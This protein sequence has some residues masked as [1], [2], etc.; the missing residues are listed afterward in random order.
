MLCPPALADHWRNEL[1][2]KFLIPVVSLEDVAATGGVVVLSHQK[3]ARS[4]DVLTDIPWDMC[5]LDEAHLLANAGLS[6]H[7][8]ANAIRDALT[9]RPKLLLTATPMQNSLLDLYHL[10]RFVDD[11]TFP[12][13]PEDFRARYMAKKAYRQELV[14]RAQMLC[15]RTLRW[16]AITMPAIRRTVRTIAVAPSP[17][18]TAL[19]R[20]LS[21]YFH[22]ENLVAFPKVKEHHIRLTYW[23]MLASSPQA[24]HESL[25]RLCERLVTVPEAVDELCEVRAIAAMAAAIA[26][27]ARA[28]AFLE[29]LAGAREQL[30]QVGAP[31]KAVVFSENTDTLDFLNGLLTRHS[32]ECIPHYSGSRSK[33][34]LLDFARSGGKILL[35]TDGAGTGLDLSHC[36]LVVNYD[37]P[38]NMQKLEQR[39]SRCHRYGQK[40]D[41]LVLN[42]ID[43]SNRADRRLY[44]SLNKKL[45][46][47]DDLFGASETLLGALAADGDVPPE[48]RTPD[49]IQADR[50]ATAEA[51]R[52]EILARVDKA[53]ADLLAHF[54][55]EVRQRFARYGETVPAALSTMN[56]WLWELTKYRLHRHATFNETA[57]IF[58]LSGSPY[59]DLRLSRITFGMDRSLPP[60]E[61][62]HLGHPLAR[63]ILAD[64]QEGEFSPGRLT[65]AAGGGFAAGLSGELGLWRLGMMSEVAHVTEPILCGVTDDGAPLSHDQCAGLLTLE[66]LTCDGGTHWDADEG[67]SYRGRVWRGASPR[68]ESRPPLR[69]ERLYA[70]RDTAFTA[71]RDRLALEHDEMLQAE[72]DRL[73]QWAE[74]EETAL[75]ARQEELRRRIAAAK[76]DAEKTAAYVQ[77]FRATQQAAE[78]E[79]K[80]RREEERLFLLAAEV[81][82]KRDQRIEE[83]RRKSSLRFWDEE[84][85]VVKF[86]VVDNTDVN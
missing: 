12:S 52:P 80:R 34:A 53:E 42:F 5:V 67:E 46:R 77:R 20:R 26:E 36:A 16:Q 38:W 2:D 50:E 22:R 54:D 61:R 83:A 62:Y 41:V 43:P 75:K 30:R 79:K 86:K 48:L 35:T 76:A 78:L 71:A 4:A 24:L 68:G 7:V 9:G 63:R 66:P 47:F 58:V 73:R 23:K 39:I 6:D 18:E 70:L 60:G 3:A 59:S 27:G 33:R 1:A 57:R 81:R 19:S 21:L 45:K 40:N 11:F 69:N 8:Q 82:R 32:H 64:C 29:A 55:D 56:R 28:K 49:A 44:D 13:D 72:L 25:T 31:Q 10:V 51:R 15:Q 84:M 37:L 17:E 74:D 14:E 65:L 85:F